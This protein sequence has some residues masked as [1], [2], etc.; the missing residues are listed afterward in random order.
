MAEHCMAD[1]CKLRVNGEPSSCPPAL[2]L[3]ELLQ[4]LGYRPEL[5]VVELN[6]SILSR[7]Q[8]PQRIVVDGDQLEVVTIV[9]GG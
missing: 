3:P 7:S 2:A 4:Q 8:W 1:H 6:G 5:V 9:G